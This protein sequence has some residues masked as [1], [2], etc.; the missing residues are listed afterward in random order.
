MSE[1]LVPT[2]A[3]KPKLRQTRLSFVER[4]SG[5]GEIELSTAVEANSSS[6]T[7]DTRSETDDGTE[8]ELED[9][10]DQSST[11]HTITGTNQCLADCCKRDFAQ[12]YQPTDSAILDQLRRRQGDRYRYFSASWYS[13]FSWLTVCITRGKVYCVVCKHCFE[14]KLLGLAKKERMHL[15]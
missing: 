3:K 15:W 10:R 12:P 6:N 13:S 1:S 11:E 9:N 7:V 8:D 14:R 5:S 4:S 2:P